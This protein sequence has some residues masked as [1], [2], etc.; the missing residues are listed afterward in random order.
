MALWRRT[1]RVASPRLGPQANH[2]GLAESTQPESALAG[3][4]SGQSAENKQEEQK[5][6]ERNMFLSP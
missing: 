1:R 5:T 3:H 4:V 6:A 2:L